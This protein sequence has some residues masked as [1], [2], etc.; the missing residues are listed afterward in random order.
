MPSYRLKT[1]LV[2]AFWRAGLTFYHLT[3]ICITEYEEELML[4]AKVN[5]ERC[6]ATKGAKGICPFCGKEVISKCGEQKVAHWAHKSKKE[7]DSW[8]DKETDWHLMWKNYFPIE[9]QEIIKHDEKTGEKHIADVCTPLQFTLEFQH[10]HIKPEERRSREDFY[11]NMNWVVDGTRLQNDFK[12]FSK[13]I[14]GSTDI[15]IIAPIHT[16]DHKF[17]VGNILEISFAE[18][19]FPKDWMDST[20]PVVFD[21]LG[22]NDISDKNDIRQC[23]FCLLPMKTSGYGRFGIQI[24]KSV[25]IEHA[26]TGVWEDFVKKTELGLQN[27]MKQQEQANKMAFYNSIPSRRYYHRRRNWWL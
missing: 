23:V 6:H 24:L 16:A 18:E 2:A 20:V 26:K 13:K 4:I 10:S 7:C 21:F 25:F 14:K 22:M 17:H 12:R 5:G 3:P 1:K 15:R 9:W 11:K 19:A 27:M 8:H